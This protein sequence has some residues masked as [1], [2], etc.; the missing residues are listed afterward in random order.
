MTRIKFKIL[1]DTFANGNKKYRI[2]YRKRFCPFW[3]SWYKYRWIDDSPQYYVDTIKEA[4]M[5]CRNL[6]NQIKSKIKIS[7]KIINHFNQ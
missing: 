4:E 2:K 7:T 5:V 3:I 6:E 1:E